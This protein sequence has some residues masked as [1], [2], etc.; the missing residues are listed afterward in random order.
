[1]PRDKGTAMTAMT[2][3]ESSTLPPRRRRRYGWWIA[4]GFV[5]SLIALVVGG[6]VLYAEPIKYFTG[7]MLT[8]NPYLAGCRTTIVREA[9]TGRLWNRMADMNCADQTIRVV[10][11]KRSDGPLPMLVFG[12]IDSPVPTSVRETGENEFEI[13]LA[14]P[15]ADGR[16]SVPFKLDQNGLTA[17][18]QIF[19]HGRAVPVTEKTDFVELFRSRV[20]KHR[21]PASE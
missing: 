5:A 15:L 10:F 14:T 8:G 6:W 7:W 2:T 21:A 19:D 9:N 17:P 4:A 3:P 20:G 11:V 16:T 12:G 13:V 18:P 1:V